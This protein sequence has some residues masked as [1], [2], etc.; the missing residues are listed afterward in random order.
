MINNYLGNSFL[1]FQAKMTIK[2]N[3]NIFYLYINSNS[4]VF[5]R[6]TLA[7]RERYVSLRDRDPERDREGLLNF[8]ILMLT[9]R[10]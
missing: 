1:N 5:V 2:F 6:V 10:V 9:S 7:I 8:Q 4:F 3:K